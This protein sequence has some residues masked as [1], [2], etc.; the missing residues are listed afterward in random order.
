MHYLAEKQLVYVGQDEILSALD[1]KTG[2]V[3][4]LYQ[5]TGPVRSAIVAVPLGRRHALLFGDQTGF[6]YAIEAESGKLIWKKRIETHDAARLTTG[7]YMA[8]T[9]GLGFLFFGVRESLRRA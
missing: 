2:C 9:F 6:F 7:V 8:L 1:A 4:W 3:Q 5:A